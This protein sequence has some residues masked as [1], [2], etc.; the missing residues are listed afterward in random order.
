[1]KV[2]WNLSHV[3]IIFQNLQLNML[4]KSLHDIL[5]NKYREGPAEGNFEAAS[6]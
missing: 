1:M 6:S 4:R 2:F 3:F 5:Y